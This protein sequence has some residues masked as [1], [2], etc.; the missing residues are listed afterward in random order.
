M[1]STGSAGNAAFFSTTSDETYKIFLR[2]YPAEE[3]IAVI[4]ADPVREWDW[5]EE[6]GGGRAIGWGAQTSHAIRQDLATP[7]GWFDSDGNEVAPETEGAQYISWGSDQSKRTPYIWTATAWLI[8]E[9]QAMREELDD[10]RMR[11]EALEARE[12]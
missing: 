10:L 1:G 9:R 5:I 3:A 6:R 12:P 8:R 4:L 2:E 7:G 11:L